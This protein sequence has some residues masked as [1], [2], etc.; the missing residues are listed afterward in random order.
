MRD[1]AQ[2]PHGQKTAASLSTKLSAR[3]DFEQCLNVFISCKS[4]T[5]AIKNSLQTTYFVIGNPWESH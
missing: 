3:E 5:N 1:D 4:G 2:V